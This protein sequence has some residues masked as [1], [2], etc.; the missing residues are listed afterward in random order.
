MAS[1]FPPFLRPGNQDSSVLQFKP[2]G[3][4]TFK[5]GA[6][7][8]YATGSDDIDECG[9]DPA[10]ILGI[11]LSDAAAKTI[12]ANGKIPVMVLD[13]TMVV[14]LSSATTPTEAVVLDVGF[15]IEKTGFWRIDITDTTATRVQ[16]LEVDIPNGIFYCRF[17]AT[18]LQGD[19]ILT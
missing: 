4:A 10:L 14:G 6:L 19:Q 1:K 7:V 16:V 9:A 15:G 11:A 12:Y 8:V 5:A 18:W 2:A 13:P 3:A 17:G